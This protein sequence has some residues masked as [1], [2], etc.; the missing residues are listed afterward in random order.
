MGAFESADLFRA[1][2]RLRAY[3]DAYLYVVR[4][5]NHGI[6]NHLRETEASLA[7]YRHA[8][9][10]RLRIQAAFALSYL[11]TVLLVLVGAV[12]LGMAAAASL[13]QPIA[14]LVQAAGRVSEGDLAARV[15]LGRDPEEIAVLSRAF[16]RMTADLGRQQEALRAASQEAQGR[17][18]FTEAVLS[19]VSAGVIG[20]D[21]RGTRVGDQS[22]GGRAP[23]PGAGFQPRPAP[24][25]DRSRTGAGRRANALGG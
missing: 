9:Q 23:G 11:E 20:L 2:Y 10:S 6:F 15:E 3:P 5:L 4:P 24:G 18:L 16:N 13:A 19:G 12:W 14:K 1:L 8:K 25:G 7:D 17:R 22:S 21:P